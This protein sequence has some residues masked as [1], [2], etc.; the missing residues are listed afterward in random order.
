MFIIM[1]AII[2]NHVSLS[3]YP[4]CK[5]LRMLVVAIVHYSKGE[6][7]ILRPRRQQVKEA[8]ASLVPEI[9]VM[10]GKLKVLL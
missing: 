3:I 9:H 2:K 5:A 7:K 10:E 4:I 1:C 8:A 6:R